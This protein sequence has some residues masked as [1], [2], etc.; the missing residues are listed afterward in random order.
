MFTGLA[1]CSV[2][3]KI[4]YDTRKLVRTFQIIKKKIIKKSFGNMVAA[5]YSMNMETVYL[6]I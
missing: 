6:L 2:T 4:S 5:V 3:L 1:G